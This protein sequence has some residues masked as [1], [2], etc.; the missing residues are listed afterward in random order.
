MRKRFVDPSATSENS[1]VVGVDNGDNLSPCVPIHHYVTQPF[2]VLNRM[3]HQPPS[4]LCWVWRLM[5][6]SIHQVSHI[7]L[8]SGLSP[9]TSTARLQFTTTIYMR[10]LPNGLYPA[11]AV[12]GSSGA[13]KIGTNSLLLYLKSYNKPIFSVIFW[14]FIFSELAVKPSFQ[15]CIMTMLHI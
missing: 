9:N 4:P 2:C 6:V 11:G 7:H 15:D 10:A 8:A 3:N 13:F 12:G 1:R 14:N 5:K